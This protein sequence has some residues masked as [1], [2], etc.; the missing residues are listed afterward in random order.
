M[1]TKKTNT[2]WLASLFAQ[3]YSF[4]AFIF[5]FLLLVFAVQ[6][7]EIDLVKGI[8]VNLRHPEYSDGTLKTDN[9]G[10]ITAE[11]IR[12]QAQR[13]LYDKKTGE[14]PVCRIEAEEDLLFEFGEY[15]FI[16]R[17]LEYDF[18]TRTGILF[19]GK[20]AVEPWFFGGKEIMLHS[21]GSYTIYN[22]FLTTSES[23]DPDWKLSTEEATLSPSHDLE[24]KNF[25]FEYKHIN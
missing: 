6:A 18:L 7:S 1:E 23:C 19:D 8:T 12:I 22:S 20:T 11:G 14:C 24:A 3:R 9:G 16:G 15:L 13:I 10:L 5:I 21:D 2:L 4:S 17:R 25:K